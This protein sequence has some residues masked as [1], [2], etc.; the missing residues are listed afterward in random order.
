MNMLAGS[1]VGSLG[2]AEHSPFYDFALLLNGSVLG[3]QTGRGVSSCWRQLRAE[4]ARLLAAVTGLC[5]PPFWC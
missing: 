2:K 5:S 4:P 1:A 3:R